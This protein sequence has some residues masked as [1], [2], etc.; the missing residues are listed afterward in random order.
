MPVMNAG[1]HKR[2]PMPPR[3]TSRQR[4]H[5]HVEHAKACGCRTLTAA[6]LMKLRRA[7]QQETR[8][9]S[10]RHIGEGRS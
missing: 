2:H 4:L 8:R 6:M 10:Q 7:A 3:A 5:W 1:W 9:S